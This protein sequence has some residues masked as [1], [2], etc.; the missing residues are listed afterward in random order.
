MV[1]VSSGSLRINKVNKYYKRRNEES[2]Q[3]LKDISLDIKSG[4]FISIVGSSGCGKST[5]LRLLVGL[6]N[7][8]VGNIEIDGTEITGTSI[9]RGIVF[10]DHRLFPW[11]SVRENVRVA[12]Q[13]SPLSRIE[14]DKLIDEHLELVGLTAF[15]EA[16][17]TQLSGGMS[18]RVAIAR[19]LVN[20]PSILLL[21]EPFGALDALTR[22]NL[23]QELQRIWQ[24][25]KITMII[26]THDVDEAV[27][28]GD[29]IVVMQP[30]PGQIKRIVPVE[31]AHPRYRDD[32]NLAIIRNNIL[33][34]FSQTPEITLIES[35]EKTIDDYQFAW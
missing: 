22:A 16:Y 17:P 13:N 15:Q 12:L 27:F 6:D 2:F 24:A 29:R 14:Q 9:K 1:D 8:Y 21:D 30:N 23:Q 34:D 10:Q 32:V 28:L 4:E 20:R 11:L 26:V 5:L 3:V 18:Q 19:A 33:A 25:E 7:T 35:V 31:I